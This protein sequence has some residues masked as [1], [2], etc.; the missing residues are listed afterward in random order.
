MN[1]V[2]WENYGWMADNLSPVDPVFFLHHSNMDRLWDV[3][4]RKQKA[5]HISDRPDDTD[6]P[7]YAAEKFLF[8]VDRAGKRVQ[9]NTA[10]DYFT[11]G[12]FDYSYDQGF[13]EEMV[14]HPPLALTAL[15]LAQTGVA[16]Q[17]S[18]GSAT[19][20]VP[21]GLS[22]AAADGAGMVTLTLPHPMTG[23]SPREYDV[24]VNAPPGTG[25]VAADSPYYA[26]TIS[27][28]GFMPGMKMGDVTFQIPLDTLPA[29]ARSGKLV[30][31]IVPAQGT[32]PMKGGALMAMAP[33]PSPLK[34]VAIT[35]AQ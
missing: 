6:W 21:A 24:L 26:G 25:S 30:F 4:S 18:G 16:A 19:L 33:M 34:S 8:Y 17:A 7:T 29:K 13:G 22:A 5:L 14:V 20:Q 23:S 31:T 35:M 10:G 11:I 15:A 32:K 27:F 3:W 28:F 2:T 12:D 9:R 1:Y